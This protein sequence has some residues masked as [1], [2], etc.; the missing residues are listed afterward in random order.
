MLLLMLKVWWQWC[1]GCRSS[2]WPGDAERP[3]GRR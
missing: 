2:P 3:S 1:T